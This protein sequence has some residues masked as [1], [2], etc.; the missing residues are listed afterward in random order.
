[1]GNGDGTE[2]R[3]GY[4]VCNVRLWPGPGNIGDELMFANVNN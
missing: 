1:M 4:T 2:D 3:K